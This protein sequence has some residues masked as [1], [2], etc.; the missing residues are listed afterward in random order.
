MMD[1]KPL[2]DEQ[3]YDWVIRDGKQLFRGRASARNR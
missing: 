3:D 1:V 2:H